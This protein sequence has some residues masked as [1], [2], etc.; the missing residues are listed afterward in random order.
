M[1]TQNTLRI[2]YSREDRKYDNLGIWL[3]EDVKQASAG[4]P[5]GATQPVGE[6]DFG[7]YFDVELSATPSKVSFLI[8]NIE[9]AKQLE[10][11]NTVYLGKNREVY[12][13]SGDPNIYDTRDL[14]IKASLRQAT[15]IESKSI[16]LM[17]NVMTGIDVENLTNNII[18]ED[19]E[20]KPIKVTSV[21]I[22]L[23]RKNVADIKVDENLLNI[24]PV[25]VTF[26]DRQVNSSVDWNYIDKTCA[27]EGDDLGCSFDGD[28]VVI[29]LWSPLAEYVKLHLF[30]RNDQTKLI[31]KKSMIK[32]EQGVWSIRLSSK[33]VDEAEGSLV[34]CYYQ[35]EIKNP[36]LEPLMALDPYA[37]SMAPVTLSS[38]GVSA[39]SSNDFVGKA[40][41]IDFKNIKTGITR[42]TIEGYKK[43][44]D[45]IVYE[46]HVRDMTSDS[47]IAD[48]LT[49]R[50]GSFKALIGCLPYIKSLGVT[51]IELLPVMAWY[52]GDELNMGKPE[53]I[54]KSKNCNYNWGY[55]PQNYFTLDGAYSEN[56]SDPELR[57]NEFR[58]LINAIH[59][60]GMGVIMDV[61]YTHM[62]STIFL[63]NI[64]PD[65]YFF[66]DKNGNFVG[67]FGNNVAT[68]HKMAAKLITDSV[69]FWFRE[70]GI[71]GMRWDMMGDAVYYLV[72]NCFEEAKKINPNVLFIGEAYKTTSVLK[73][74]PGLR[75]KMADVDWLYKTLDVGGYCD[76]IRDEIK[77][78]FHHI[79]EGDPRFISNGPRNIAK[80]FSNLKGQPTGFKTS[81]P[82]SAVQYIEAHDNMTALDSLAK[83]TGLDPEVPECYEELHRRLRLGL[84]LILTAQG[85]ILFHAGLEYGRTKQWLGLEM[86]EQKWVKFKDK[87]GKPFIHPY[88]IRDSYASSD[89]IN[90]FD[91]EK[92]TD[93]RKYPECVKTVEFS[94]GMIALRKSTEVFR[95][96][97]NKAVDANMKL[98]DVPEIKEEDLAIAYSCHS[99]N[100]NK[101]YYVFVNADNKNRKFTITYDL[102]K[103]EIIADANR[104][105]I[106][107]ITEP[108]GVI[109]TPDSIELA[110]LTLTIIRL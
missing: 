84:G 68:S 6:D 98:L 8:L 26:G 91:W 30:A 37:K 39:G 35:F 1:K 45:A 33:D 74:E 43:R 41:I 83:A 102:T 20:G 24:L 62:A 46:A 85:T 72:Q 36:G 15:I 40:A 34:G 93:A 89:A 104:A 32:G 69:K 51:H 70:F 96:G 60:E 57:I 97:S 80:L 7:I 106:A 55:D 109:V 4:W 82:G 81:S 28:A 101:T 16:R 61:V 13:V 78:G 10:A 17:F 105:G 52:W 108:A 44:E 27:Y 79:G 47:S 75:G 3:W 66:K 12:V 95:L 23:A 22:S 110:P 9:K 77:S 94:K 18:M 71:D 42:G 53:Y 76:E 59:K 99:E 73:A 58:E 21:T 63:N 48:K 19:C 103:A 92:A 65:Y 86:P 29:K 50:F 38:D 56:P 25:K 100:E 11:N 54:Y 64:I 107:P 49:G 14:K 67:Q 5:D 2:H 88:F 90:K 87:A 31:S